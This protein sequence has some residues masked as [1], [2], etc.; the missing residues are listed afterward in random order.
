MSVLYAYDDLKRDI[1]KKPI[2]F[3]KLHQLQ[4][5]IG[6]L[7][8]AYVYKE[9][10]KKLKGTK[11]LQMIDEKKAL[12]PSN[13]YDILS[14]TRDGKPLHIEVKATSG[15]ENVFYLSRH[16]WKTAERMKKEGLTYVVYFI[17]EIMSDNPILTE[18][19]DITSNKEYNFEEYGYKVT[20]A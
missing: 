18:I 3:L 2:D 8:E 17:K 13:G 11:F 20:K 9:E 6:K 4:I 5:E 15:K 1:Q 7:G 12:V 19:N 16:E 10:S 14:F